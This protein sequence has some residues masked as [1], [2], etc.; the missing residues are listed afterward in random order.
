MASIAR[1]R[2]QPVRSNKAKRSTLLASKGREAALS[3]LA[4]ILEDQMTEVGLS[5]GAK[6][7]KTAELVAFVSATA[8][9]RFA[10]RAKARS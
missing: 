6:N 4:A 9:S 5:E 7:E 8:S 2:I 1:P 10:S 3:E